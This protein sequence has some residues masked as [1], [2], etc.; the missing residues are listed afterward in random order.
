[1]LTDSLRAVAAA[2]PPEPA[3]T[4]AIRLWVDAFADPHLTVYGQGGA[5]TR[6]GGGG[7]PG[8]G[9]G[10]GFSVRFLDDGT[11]LLRLPTFEL[12]RRATIDS[13]VAAHRERLL[14]TPLL[15]IDVRG[16]GGG[17]SGSYRALLPLLADG[18]IRVRGIEMWASEG[19]LAAMRVDVGAASLPAELAEQ[20]RAVVHRMESSIGRFVTLQPDSAIHPERVHPYPRAVGLLIDRGCASACEQFVL[21][22]RQSGK[23]TVFGAE[24]TR[25]ALDYLNV[26][27][28]RLPSGVRTLRLPI[29]RLS[30]LPADPVN[31]TGLAP[32]VRLAPAADPVAHAA[33]HLSPEVSPPSGTSPS[34]SPPSGTAR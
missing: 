31:P 2:E 25:G 1:M 19:N 22:A 29:S 7:A 32:D 15:L 34:A 23:V 12:A 6:G 20:I 16:N 3:C 30:G 13:L 18:P 27:T 5:A 24:N 11:A 21:E 26:R 8:R 9:G 10:R 33:R 17:W 4:A 14:A 28:A